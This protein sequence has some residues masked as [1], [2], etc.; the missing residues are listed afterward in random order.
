MPGNPWWAAVSA[1]LITKSGLHQH[2]PDFYQSTLVLLK[3][4]K[5]EMRQRRGC[6]T[7]HM[8]GPSTTDFLL[9][10]MHKMLPR[11]KIYLRQVLAQTL[12]RMDVGADDLFGFNGFSAF[13]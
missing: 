9:L 11:K 2:F 7:I 1:I 10:G 6:T 5:Y 13:S 8:S 12:A 3:R 4:I